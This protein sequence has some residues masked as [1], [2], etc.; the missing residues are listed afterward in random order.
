MGKS[1]LIDRI[2]HIEN[3]LRIAMEF[4]SKNTR[5]NDK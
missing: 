4:A 2:D 1:E 5:L 3:S